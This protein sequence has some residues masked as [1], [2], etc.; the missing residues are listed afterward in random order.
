MKATIYFD[1]ACMPYNPGGIATYGFVIYTEDGEKFTGSGIASEKGTNNIAEYT[2]LIKALEKA[3]ELGIVEATV[4]GDS[5]LAIY[6]M[7]GIYEVRSPNIIPLY[8]KAIELCKHFKKIRFQWI[9]RNENKEADTLSEKVYLE[10]WERKNLK[11]LNT[12]KEWKRI[13]KGIYEINGYLV[14]LNKKT[15]DC[16]FFK[17]ML[18]NP[19]HKRSGIIIK[20]KHIL[21]AENLEKEHKF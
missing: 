18:N 10:Y 21:F 5:Q 7:N 8:E 12:I 6:Q 4:K 17:K 2:A 14:D 15:C 16:E 3:I 11:K 19:L 9:P 13:E 1:G 20:C